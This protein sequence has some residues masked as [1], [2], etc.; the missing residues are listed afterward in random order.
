[1]RTLDELLEKLGLAAYVSKFTDQEVDL[2]TF[3]T[4]SEGDLQV[5]ACV[6]HACGLRKTR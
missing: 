1:M 6:D 4:L 2:A 3:L 5:R